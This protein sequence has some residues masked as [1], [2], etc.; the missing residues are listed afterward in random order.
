M[1]SIKRHPWWTAAVSVLAFVGVG[2]FLNRGVITAALIADDGVDV[3]L[4]AVEPL[5]P[6]PRETIYRI[7]PTESSATVQV[8]ETL[9][10]VEG[11][12]DLVTSGIAGDI[13]VADGATAV[14]LG[15]V[16]VNVHQLASDNAL[17][18]KVI[19][20]EF[21]ESHEHPEVR[22]D[23]AT[24]TLPGS[25]S[26]T[27]VKRA[28][29]QGTLHVKGL[30]VPTTWTASARIEG[31][32]LT[33]TATTKVR[34]SDLGVGPISKAGLVRTGDDMTVTLRLTARD[35]A[36]FVPPAVLT[37]RTADPRD[38][39]V[40]GRVPSFSREV[41]PILE[42]SC[43]SCHRKGAIGAST[44]TLTTA[45]DAASVADGLAVVTKS[46]YMP[47]WPPSDEG[48]PL[49]H[50]RT[51]RPAQIRTI[52]DWAKAG[53][54]LDV[55]RSR[56]VRVPQGADV[57]RPRADV[58]VHLAEPYQGSPERRDDYRCFILDP[59][60][61]EPTFM[62]GYTFDPDRLEVVHHALVYQ[63]P[64][65][66]RPVDDARDTAD[67][68]S[69]WSCATG[70]GGAGGGAL[71]AGWVL[72][73]RPHDFGGGVGF[74]FQPG[75]YL[76]AQIH[77]HYETGAPPDRSGMTLQ[78]STDPTTVALQT[79]TLIGPVEI[80]CPDGSTEGL[81]DRSAAKADVDARF[82]PGSSFV[83]DALNRVCRTTPEELA[84]TSDGITATTTC[85]YRIRTSGDVVDVLGHMHQIGSSYRMTL[86]PDTPD[87]K[88]LLDIPVWNF[89]WQLNYQPVDPVPVTRGDTVR[90]SCSWDRRLRHDP[91]LRY[92]VFAEGTEDEMCFS[93]VTIRPNG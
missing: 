77:Y 38:P 12:V 83:S 54:P 89:N 36:G 20:H 15:A 76:V 69:G 41:A 81:C 35:A 67:P 39:T 30:A 18:D 13:G 55:P 68:G 37:A 21:L 34:M 45:G 6:G 56:K 53:A 50:A 51:L 25:A 8:T 47:P 66:H 78:T 3:T 87:A 24:V 74:A 14:R 79:S 61:G 52:V 10:G 73:Q 88:V 75:D 11:R 46:G 92:I 48:V 59:K 64:A 44:W 23:D 80:P 65:S 28:A 5:R 72:G 57:P 40:G 63:L 93:T 26:P 84:A 43:A 42:Q 49:S 29:I 86:N 70:M 58:T 7:D 17:R 9:A 2:A 27:S 4:P 1:R 33:A 62:T 85:D 90:V 16:A 60:F 82:G 91:V 32:T 31:A 22:L 19:R 71:V